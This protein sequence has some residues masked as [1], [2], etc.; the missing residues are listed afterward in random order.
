LATRAFI[1]KTGNSG[2]L[3][4]YPK[5]DIELDLLKMDENVNYSSSGVCAAGRI[6]VCVTG[7]LL[8]LANSNA[9]Y[10]KLSSGVKTLFSPILG[11]ILIRRLRVAQAFRLRIGIA[12][13]AKDN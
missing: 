9:I 6:L 4:I 12:S 1:P 3:R 13:I 8:R 5:N 2:N 7:V 10:T 11:N